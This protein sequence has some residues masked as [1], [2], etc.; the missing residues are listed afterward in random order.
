[1]KGERTGRK[2]KRTGRKCKIPEKNEILF[3]SIKNFMKVSHLIVEILN[4][5]NCKDHKKIH[6]PTT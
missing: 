1:M 6:N 4:T 3:S 5:G 2:K